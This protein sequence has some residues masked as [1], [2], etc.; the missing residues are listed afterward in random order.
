MIP[1]GAVEDT[2]A[3][4]FE[5]VDIVCP[6]GNV[7]EADGRNEEPRV[8]DVGPPGV[9]FG[10]GNTPKKLFV[11]PLCSRTLLLE[12]DVARSIERQ[13][14]TLNILENLGLRGVHL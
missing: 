9:S 10:K 7:A 1:A 13:H 8:L 5:V 2:A 12:I 4:L 11:K 6:I 14:H 3:E